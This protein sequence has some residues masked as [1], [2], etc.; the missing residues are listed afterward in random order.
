MPVEQLD[1][2]AYARRHDP[3]TSHKAAA[4][5]AT[6]SVNARI[7]YALE[8]AGERG[9]T[10]KELETVTG[11]PRVTI[12]PRMKPLEEGAGAVARTQ[13][14]RDGCYVYIRTQGG[15]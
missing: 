5:L 13:E 7:L 14:K 9:F 8:G 6:A 10:T 2:A 1:L 3:E 15:P 12:S 4:R 11:I